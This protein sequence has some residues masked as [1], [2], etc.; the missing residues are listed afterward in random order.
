MRALAAEAGVTVVEGMVARNPFHVISSARA[1]RRLLKASPFAVAHI[2]TVRA[3]ILLAGASVHVFRSRSVSTIHNEFQRSAIAMCFTTRVVCVSAA[4][5][6]AIGGRARFVHPVVIRNGNVG[7]PR[8]AELSEVVPHPLAPKSI[9]FVGALNARKGVDVLLEAMVRVIET[10]PDARLY[11]V[12][13]RDNP[14]LEADASRLGL[15]EVV[16]FVGFSADPRSYLLS[17]SVFVLPS[18]AEPFGLV[19]LEARAAGVPIIASDVGGIPEVLSG[20]AAGILVPV[21]DEVAL[22]E[23]IVRVLDDVELAEELGARAAAGLEPFTVSRMVGEYDKLYAQ[24][25]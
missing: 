21:G 2:H 12:G 1:L 9:V 3:A 23:A 24:L 14:Q 22:A 10:N 5:A 19:L 4:D 7:S 11:L 18:R 20:G 8:L 15:D 6:A 25:A 16:D 13:N 17:A